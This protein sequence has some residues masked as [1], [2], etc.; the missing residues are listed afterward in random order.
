MKDIIT[1]DL[2]KMKSS[3]QESTA[4]VMQLL[5]ESTEQT[6]MLSEELNS[7]AIAA[8]ESLQ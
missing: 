6:L 8:I 7:S 3:A 4:S 5:L 2:L 1:Q